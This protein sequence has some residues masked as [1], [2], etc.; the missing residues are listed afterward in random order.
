MYCSAGYLYPATRGGRRPWPVLHIC[1]PSCCHDCGFSTGFPRPHRAQ[2]TWSKPG[3]CQ[4]GCLTI[5]RNCGLHLSRC[6]IERRLSL[7]IATLSESVA[8]RIKREIKP[9]SVNAIPVVCSFY[10]QKPR[11]QHLC[12]VERLLDYRY[13][14]RFTALPITGRLFRLSRLNHLLAR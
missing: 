2:R 6:R 8:S 9:C 12:I 4:S 14:P 11:R 7:L 5:S 1:E 13:Q 10:R 3:C